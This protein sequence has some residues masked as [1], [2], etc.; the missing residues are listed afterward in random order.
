MPSHRNKC[1]STPSCHSSSS[2]DTVSDCHPCTVNEKSR[3]HKRRTNKCKKTINNIHNT[4]EIVTH[5]RPEVYKTSK[6]KR[7]TVTHKPIIKKCV[8]SSSSES[9]CTSGK[10]SSESSS[11]RDCYGE[12]RVYK[13]NKSRK[14]H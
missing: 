1:S 3:V 11:D 2:S 13:Q 10:S 8:L 5:L 4:H 14:H 9:Y 12:K 6:V 7:I